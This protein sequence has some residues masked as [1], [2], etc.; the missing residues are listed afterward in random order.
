MWKKIA[1]G[2]L[3]AIAAAVSLGF[4]Y[5]YL[6]K[7]AVAPPLAIRVEM[8]PERIERGRFLFQK[9]ADCE[10]CHSERDF[11]RFGGPVTPGGLGKGFVFPAELG[12][13]GTV[14][15]PNLTPD[16]ETGLGQWTDG[17]KIRAI[18]EGISRDGRVLFPMMPY[19]YFRRMSDEDVQAV[20]AY[21][22]S[23]PPVR[24]ALPKTRIDFP[25]SMLM[26]S[27]PQPAG[28][29]ASA[30]RGDKLKYGEYLV[31]LGGCLECHTKQD[32]GEPLPGMLLAGGR[33]FRMP[34]GVVVSAN[35]TPDADTGI[36]KWNEQQFL[37]KFYQYKDYAAQGSPQVGPEGFTLMPWLNLSQ[38]S[39]EE[40]GAIFT[41]LKSQSPVRNAVETHPGYPGKS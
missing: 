4:G 3:G 34:M 20:V 41:Y 27:A 17:E 31:T 15:A 18:R 7:P 10:G 38:L 28:S 12:L 23:L 9:M 6:R 11:T 32:K 36:G 1:L 24:N 2:T 16:M 33:E 25:V 8:T 22:N 13:P 5:L 26:K 30:D 14:V 37:D 35:I 39:P 29:V 40:L 21:L 19:T